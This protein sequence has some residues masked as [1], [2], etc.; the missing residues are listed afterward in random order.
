M[1]ET[2][3][4]KIPVDEIPEVWRKKLSYKPTS[5]FLTVTIAEPE[6][7]SLSQKKSLEDMTQEEVNEAFRKAQELTK[8]FCAMLKEGRKRQPSPVGG[9]IS[10]Y[11]G[12]LKGTFGSVEEIDAYIRQERDSWD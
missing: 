4:Y 5:S 10:K 7:P 9:D 1:P 8:R 12:A 2:T 11:V 3:F 6:N